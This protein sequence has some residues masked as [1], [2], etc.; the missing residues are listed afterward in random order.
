MND[1]LTADKQHLQTQT[2]NGPRVHFVTLGCPK[3]EVDTD[4]MRGILQSS[5]YTVTDDLTQADVAV[6]N[7]CGFIQDAVEESITEALELLE[8][9][10]EALGRK[11]VMAGCM[12]SRYGIDLSDSLPEPDAF[13]PVKRAD[14]LPQVLDLLFGI[15]RKTYLP[16]AAIKR[17]GDPSHFAYLMISDGCRK[18]CAYCTIPL[19]R[20]PYESR[21]LGAIVAEARFLVASGAS[22]IILI[23]QDISSWGFDLDGSQTL[24][25]VVREVSALE[26]VRWLRLMYMQPDG[27]TNELLE[28]IAETPNVCNYLDIPLQHA[29]PAI[30]RSMRRAGS[31]VS[32]MALLDNIRR[33][34]PDIALRTTFIT[35]FP[36]ETK[37]HYNEVVE[38]VENAVFDYVGVFPYSR[39]SGTLAAE[40]PN[41]VSSKV[42]RNRAQ[43]LRDLAD[44]LAVER[45]A[46]RIGLTL[47]VVAEGHDEEGICFGRWRGQAPEI[48]GV[49]FLDRDVPVGQFVEVKIVDVIGYDLAGEVI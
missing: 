6:L 47:E 4:C 34:I 40:M 8:W 41:Q 14:C 3:N 44:S 25:D 22:E 49:V 13:I 16:P 35:G 11:L 27:I 28:L 42:R 9:R 45:I 10:D 29:S 36:G 48:D 33:I 24:I 20:G 15:D 38:F 21:P 17:S 1:T 26:G 23:G 39:E 18:Q 32:F 37:A 30:L 7:T 12:V 31:S 5:R 46:Q 19:I 2:G 43:R